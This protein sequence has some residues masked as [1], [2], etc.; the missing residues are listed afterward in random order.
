VV[1]EVYAGSE[2]VLAFGV[3]EAY[4]G[5]EAMLAL[6]IAVAAECTEA[7]EIEGVGDRGPETM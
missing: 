1:L 7:P 3:P 2:A 5:R 4:E 6:G